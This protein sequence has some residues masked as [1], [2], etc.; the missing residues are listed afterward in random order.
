VTF[1]VYEL[2]TLS[3]QFKVRELYTFAVLPQL[4]GRVLFISSV[5]IV[6]EA[7]IMGVAN[8]GHHTVVASSRPWVQA[9]IGQE[10]A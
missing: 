3:S 9:K 2:E 6:K 8:V 4:M 7:T 10:A 1:A 5:H